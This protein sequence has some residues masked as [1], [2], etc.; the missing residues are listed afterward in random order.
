MQV[1]L[2]TLACPKAV[3]IRQLIKTGMTHFYVKILVS[4]LSLNLLPEMSELNQMQ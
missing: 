4:I 1:V 3:W 2:S